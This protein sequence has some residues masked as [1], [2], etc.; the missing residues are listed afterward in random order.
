MRLIVLRST[1]IRVEHVLLLP[2]EFHRIR[3][4]RFTEKSSH[5]TIDLDVTGAEKKFYEVGRSGLLLLRRGL[6]CAR[7]SPRPSGCCM[8]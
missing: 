6:R 7:H 2:V 8:C 1:W 3:L 4:A 5:I